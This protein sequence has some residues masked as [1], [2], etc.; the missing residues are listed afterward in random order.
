VVVNDEGIQISNGGRDSIITGGKVEIE[1]TGRAG[2]LRI[3]VD[4]EQSGVVRIFSDAVVERGQKVTGDVVAVFG[5]VD[6]AGDVAGDV[7]AVF[8][9]VRLQRGASVDGDVVAVGGRLHQEEGSVVNGETVSVGF[10]PFDGVGMPPLRTLLLLV[11]VGWVL[12]MIWGALFAWIFPTRLLRVAT[13]S[14][15]RTAAT[16][17][18]GIMAIPLMLVAMVLLFVTVIGIPLAI[19]LPPLFLVLSTGG[20]QAATY[21]LGC[22]LMRRRIGE[23]S[24]LIAPLAVGNLFVALFFAAGVVLGFGVP[25]ARPAGLFFGVLGGLLQAALGAIG[26]GAFLLSRLGSRPTDV[27]RGGE[28]IPGVGFAEAAAPPAGA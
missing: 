9:S 24:N 4:D 2:D 22:K 13:T 27:P 25:A 20:Q 18:L 6:C 3:V 11:G 8:G 10:L 23:G 26:T 28:P 17:V 5:S 16:L 19:L 1:R 15:R 21:V 12:S 14:S 7:V